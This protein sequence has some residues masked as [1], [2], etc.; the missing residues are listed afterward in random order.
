MV[1]PSPETDAS[2]LLFGDPPQQRDEL[3]RP[4]L[5][6]PSRT[7][8]QRAP[9]TGSHP[10]T[11][12]RLTR[13]FAQQGMRGWVP[14]T[15]EV[16]PARRQLR[17]PERVRQALQRLK[18]LYAGFGA[19]ELARIIFHTTMYCLTG[20][21]GVPDVSRGKFSARKTAMTSSLVARHDYI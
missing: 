15:Q 19:R 21:T 10:A 17:V 20:R 5:L 16:R 2:P 3:I 7:T 1:Q 8:A 12:G 4:L 18:G 13:R 14:T 11:V 9:E 6:D